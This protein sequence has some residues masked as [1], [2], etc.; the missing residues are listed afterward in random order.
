MHAPSADRAAALVRDVRLRELGAEF[1]QQWRGGTADTVVLGRAYEDSMIAARARPFA[2]VRVRTS[3]L[4][5]LLARRPRH[6]VEV[7]ERPGA[8]AE[9]Y[10]IRGMF[11]TRS[12]RAR[13]TLR[14]F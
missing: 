13:W 12:A 3:W 11:A 14:L 5:P 7:R 1:T 9:Y 10:V 8:P 4:S 6:L 2:S